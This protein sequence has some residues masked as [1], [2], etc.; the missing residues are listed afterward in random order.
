MKRVIASAALLLVTASPAT[1]RQRAEHALNRL[2][3]GARP[4]DVERVVRIGVD[5][6]LEQ[7]LHPE[8][9]DDR[10]A[11]ARVAKYGVAIAPERDRARVRETDPS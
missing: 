9:L 5:R 1:E 11:E 4:D 3:F 10:K 8:R 2:A 6:W 7:Q